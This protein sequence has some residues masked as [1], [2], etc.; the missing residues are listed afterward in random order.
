MAYQTV[1]EFRD[2]TIMPG[3]DV[4]ELE[5]RYPNFLSSRL[6]IWS[7]WLDARLRKRYA[8]P[9]EAPAPLIVIG[10]LTALVTLDAYARRGFNPSGEADQASIIAPADRA[11]AEVKEAAD[12]KEG[13]F[14]LPL[15]QDAAG[16][17]GIVNGGPLGYSEASPYIWAD[18]QAIAGRREDTSRG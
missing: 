6:A 10:W 2:R 14:D 3:E 13:L 5:S 9:F 8:T 11:M 15:R 18:L 7:A 4:D 17:S 1:I 12:S 16:S